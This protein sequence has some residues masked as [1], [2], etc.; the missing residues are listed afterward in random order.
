MFLNFDY[1]TMQRVYGWCLQF[2]GW[3]FFKVQTEGTVVKQFADWPLSIT[4]APTYW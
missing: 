1:K 4:G 2:P 3:N